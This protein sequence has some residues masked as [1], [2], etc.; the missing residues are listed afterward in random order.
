MI[1]RKVLYFY[2]MQSPIDQNVQ[3]EVSF[4]PDIW[5]DFEDQTEFW[6]DL[7]DHTER[8]SSLKKLGTHTGVRS[9]N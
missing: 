4:I 5:S 2:I 8:L 7:E 9:K 3:I 6:T 1:S